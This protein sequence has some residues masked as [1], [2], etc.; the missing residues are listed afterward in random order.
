MRLGEFEGLD[1]LDLEAPKQERFGRCRVDTARG[2]KLQGLTTHELLAW[3]DCAVE[4]PSGRPVAVD[5]R[6][7]ETIGGLLS[8]DEWIKANPARAG[9]AGCAREE[10]AAPTDRDLGRAQGWRYEGDVF[11][12]NGKVITAQRTYYR[13]W[14]RTPLWGAAPESAPEPEPRRVVVGPPESEPVESGETMH[15][16][17]WV[18]EHAPAWRSHAQCTVAGDLAATGSS[19][20]HETRADAVDDA[21]RSADAID[22][23]VRDERARKRCR[24]AEA[25]AEQPEPEPGPST[26]LAQL[27]LFG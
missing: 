2:R 18:C 17:W 6:T 15:A 12:I 11:R 27:G 7:G 23:H 25:E 1:E 5:C 22:R 14:Q 16:R 26:N 3:L 13:H 24:D 9:E 21:K 4:Y 10:A 20:V 19:G 8:I